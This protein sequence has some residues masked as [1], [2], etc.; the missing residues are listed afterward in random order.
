MI[1]KNDLHFQHF[2]PKWT[3]T[4]PQMI[5]LHSEHKIPTKMV[6]KRFV[7]AIILFNS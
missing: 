7:D 1:P 2:L 5:V 6:D 4:D 3:K